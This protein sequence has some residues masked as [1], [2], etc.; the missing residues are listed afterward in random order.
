MRLMLSLGTV[1][2]VAE[3]SVNGLPVGIHWM[4]DQDFAVEKFLHSGKNSL[5]VEVTNTLINRVSGL[6]ALPGIAP[7]LQD[8]LGEGVDKSG[9]VES[10]LLGFEPLPPSGLLG[11]VVIAPAKKT[12]VNVHTIPAPPW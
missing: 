4:R 10:R 9:R 3:I 11:P 12:L 5:V 8:R 7:E 1:G 6:H 2:T